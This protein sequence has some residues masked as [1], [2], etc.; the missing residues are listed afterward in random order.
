MELRIADEARLLRAL[1]HQVSAAISPFP[2]S[3]AFT[4]ILATEG[5][6]ICSFNP[7]PFFEQWHWRRWN[8]VRALAE[9]PRLRRLGVNLAHVF[10]AWT[11]TG[12]SRLWLCHKAG[13]PCVI[14]VHNSFPPHTLTPWHSRLMAEAFRSVRAIYG[15]SQSALD[16]FMAIYGAFV[17]EK[18]F[19]EVVH[20]FVDVETFAPNEHTRRSIRIRLGIPS[21]APL[22]GSIG[23][24]DKQK[25]PL[26]VLEVFRMVR[27]ELP[28]AHLL[29]VG[30]GPLHAD[31]N[32]A[33]ARYGLSAVVRLL[34]FRRDIQD[35]FSALDVHL[36]LSRQEGFGITSVEALASGV[37]VVATDVPGTKDVLGGCS[38]ARLVPYGDWIG[39]AKTCLEVLAEGRNER[40]QQARQ[41]AVERYSKE[42]W[43]RKLTRFYERA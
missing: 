14:S 23:R 4:S 18:T 20:N 30:N 19:L 11:Q 39:V 27:S 42:R 15:V 40:V 36:L 34:A 22:L 33:I 28:S 37:P 1:G 3:C 6:R 2:G 29:I 10:Y 24:L 8:R 12:G 21:E 16:H 43:E 13:I 5:S 26:S 31:V 9:L 17:N 32:E 38:A 35:Y 41:F 7:S 25:D